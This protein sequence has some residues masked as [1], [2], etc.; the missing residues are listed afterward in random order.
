MITNAA[1]RIQSS[2]FDVGDDNMQ[3]F[4]ESYSMPT[5]WPM[6]VWRDLQRQFQHAHLCPDC[7]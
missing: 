7:V 5:E 2:E 6:I 4:T 3:I 1:L